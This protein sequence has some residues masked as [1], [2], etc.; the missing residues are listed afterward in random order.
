MQAKD[1]HGKRGIVVRV[2]KDDK[3][4][5]EYILLNDVYVSTYGTK[6]AIVYYFDGMDHASVSVPATHK[7]AHTRSKK[8]LALKERFEKFKR[9]ELLMRQLYHGA[10]IKAIGSDPEVFAESKDGRLMPAFE[11]LGS[12]AAP[13]KAPP[14]TYGGNNCYWDGYQ[15][16]FDT[17]ANGCLSYHVDS[18]RNGLFGVYEALKKLD[19]DAVLS[20]RTTFDIPD[21]RL[22]AD[23]DEHVMFGCMPSKNAYN[24]EGIKDDGRNVEFRSA[25]GHIHL[26]VKPA[27]EAE[28]IK[29]VKAM[30]AVLGVAC[31]SLFAKFDDARRRK[32][33]GLAGEYRLPPHGVEYRVLSNAWLS[34]PLI[35][36]IVMDLSRKAYMAGVSGMIKDWKCDEK[37][38]IRIINECDVAAARKVLEDNNEL[39]TLIV[40]SIY[41]STGRG[42][43]VV[44]IFK[45]GI[46]SVIAK[47]EDIVGNW[48][49]DVKGAWV[50]HCDGKETSVMHSIDALRD[51]KKVS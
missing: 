43:L 10:T 20:V 14:G 15:A 40:G 45:N 46:E 50:D 25:G 1:F 8:A 33:Y 3:F 32:M 48:K 12:K 2:T 36:N 17:R 21:Y 42:E 23:A 27:S 24:M 49:L 31:V 13:T 30:D 22:R 4:K 16:E 51:K 41:N 28:I 11:F 5:S 7:M 39:F 37:E 26:E 18:I 29:G 44:D 9:N 35:T 34:H 38:T 6:Q 19:K 47:P